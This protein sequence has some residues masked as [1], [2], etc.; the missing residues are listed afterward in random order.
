MAAS[1]YSLYA[2]EK[3]PQVTHYEYSDARIKQPLKILAISDLHITKMIAPQKV[4][5]WV[6]QFNALQP[7]VIVMPGD[8]AD[9]KSEDIRRHIME[10]K[11]LK[12]PHGIF[13]I[14]GNHEVD[15][16]AVTWE[17]VFAGLGWQVLH[18]S[19]VSLPENG[20][21]VGGLPDFG[22][23]AVNIGQT[24]RNAAPDEY[25]ILLAHQPVIAEKIGQ[26]PVDLLIAGHTH[27]G[28]IFPFNVLVK[29]GNR[30]FVRGEY[31][32]GNTKV[33]IANGAGYWGPPM[34]LA[35]PAEVMM[36]ELKPTDKN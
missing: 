17:A 4:A 26:N 18:N 5:A 29:M 13:Y 36:I 6:A 16:D 20:V 32:I 30:G 3:L 9:D 21:Y 8:I 10:L 19:G 1:L 11:K 2:A 23:F 25:R 14:V 33:L 15:H 31:A 28:Q 22:G 24:L 7:D 12:A 35:A 34:R 27:G